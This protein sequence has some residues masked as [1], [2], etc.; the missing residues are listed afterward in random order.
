MSARDCE[1]LSTPLG[2]TIVVTIANGAH[3]VRV[4]RSIRDTMAK[5]TLSHPRRLEADHSFFG[6]IA[7]FASRWGLSSEELNN[8]IRLACGDLSFP[9]ILLQNPCNSHN[10]QYDRMFLPGSTLH[11]VRAVLEELNLTMDDICIWDAIPLI[12]THW[13]KSRSIKEQRKVVEEAF[14]LTVKF[15]ET[16]QPK[17]VV[18]CQCATGSPCHE[19]GNITHTFAQCISSSPRVAKTHS[20]FNYRISTHYTLSVVKAFHPGRFVWKAL[21]GEEKSLKEL[22]RIIFTPCAKWKSKHYKITNAWRELEIAIKA[23]IPKLDAYRNALLP[24]RYCCPDSQSDRSL[25]NMAQ[26]KLDQ[27]TD[28]VRGADGFTKL[29]ER[30]RSSTIVA[31]SKDVATD[32]LLKR[33]KQLGL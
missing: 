17:T 31:T 13:L 15:F 1:P 18:S 23:T 7:N 25:L 33:L 28:I 27:L 16:F 29:V 4:R 9:I 8:N 24:L 22:F 12:S 14:A 19:F 5:Y 32:D 10:E 2:E 3:Y 6:V 20:V 26:E 11:W 30:G 21:P